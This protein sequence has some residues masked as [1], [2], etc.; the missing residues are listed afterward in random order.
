M[1][2]SGKCQTNLSLESQPPLLINGVTVVWGRPG[3]IPFRLPA[4]KKHKKGK[5]WPN[6]K[7]NGGEEM[8]RGKKREQREKGGRDKITEEKWG[9]GQ[10][11]LLPPF[12]V[13]SYH[14]KHSPREISVRLLTRVLVY[15]W[16]QRMW[17]RLMPKPH[18]VT[19]KMVW[20]WTTNLSYCTTD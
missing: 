17:L 9:E 5:E 7:R 6:G 10:C 3:C 19:R 20:W 8:G 13:V 18:L 4:L 15:E 16:M 11:C 14:H 2:I 1:V 12:R